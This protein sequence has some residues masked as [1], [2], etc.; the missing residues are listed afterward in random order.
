MLRPPKAHHQ[1]YINKKT[2]KYLRH[3]YGDLIILLRGWTTPVRRGGVFF[4]FL[5]DTEFLVPNC[6]YQNYKTSHP[7]VI[8][9]FSRQK[10]KSH[11]TR[12]S[13]SIYVCM[14]VRMDVHIYSFI[15]MFVHGL[16]NKSV[17]QTTQRGMT[18]WL[19]NDELGKKRSWLN[20][21]YTGHVW[22][23][24]KRHAASN[25]RRW[26]QGL[27]SGMRCRTF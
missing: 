8:S 6:R 17:I 25:W 1:A 2:V 26:K 3:S 24:E 10:I 7:R 11:K 14:Y 19:T 13:V 27:S 16:L 21:K 9:T 20:W 18:G 23:N 22:R 4:L 15:C 12:H 5:S